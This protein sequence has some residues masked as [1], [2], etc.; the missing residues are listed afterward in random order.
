MVRTDEFSM[1]SNPT[2]FDRS[3]SAA[4]G[5]RLVVTLF[6]GMAEIVGARHVEIEWHGGTVADLR[7][8]MVATR[9]AI[10]PL[11]A[12]SAVAVAGRYAADDRPIAAGADVAIIPPVSGG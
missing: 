11:L 4:I 5:Q 9:P 12:R 1:S 6:A 2:P 3:S 10:G 8:D 7:R